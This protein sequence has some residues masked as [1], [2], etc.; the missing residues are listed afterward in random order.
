MPTLYQAF[1]SY[2]NLPKSEKNN[3]LKD[4]HTNS[5]D[6]AN[7]LAALISASQD[8]D[9]IGDVLDQ[10]IKDICENQYVSLTKNHKV[11]VY[12]VDHLLGRGGMSSVYLAHRNDGKF[13]Q[14]V[15]LKFLSSLLTYNKSGQI[16]NFEAQALSKLNHPN[17]AKIHGLEASIEQQ[18]CLVIEYIEGDTLEQYLLKN[19]IN[20]QQ[21]L[22]LFKKI[23]HAIQ[24]AHSQKIIHGDIKPTNIIITPD[25]QPKIIDFGVS[26]QDDQKNKKLIHDYLCALSLGYASPEQINGDSASTLSDVY[27]LGA[28]LS[29]IFIGKTPYQLAQNDQQ[30]LNKTV[31]LPVTLKK[32][33]DK[34]SHISAEKR[35]LTADAIKQDI[36]LYQ[37][38]RPLLSVRYS[39][40]RSFALFYKRNT[41][42]T[43]L[44]SVFLL[45]LVLGFTNFAY[46]N[47]QLKSEQRANT[48]I[49]RSMSKLLNQIDPT[50]GNISQEKPVKA[51]ESL[52][53]SMNWQELNG[54]S[55]IRYATYL[56]SAYTSVDEV[57]KAITLLEGLSGV[58]PKSLLDSPNATYL[59]K[60]KLADL[61]FLLKQHD[62]STENFIKSLSQ[63]SLLTLD[64]EEILLALE[65]RS[66]NIVL[67]STEVL[68]KEFIQWATIKSNKKKLTVRAQVA[69]NSFKVAYYL[70]FIRQKDYQKILSLSKENLALIRKNRETLPAFYY[71]QALIDYYDIIV[72]L[73]GFNHPE[74]NVIPEELRSLLGTTIKR[75]HP[76]YVEAV[77]HLF[78]IFVKTNFKAAIDLYANNRVLLLN[79][80][81]HN[82]RLT[83]YLSR[84]LLKNGEFSEALLQNYQGIANTNSTYANNEN[85]Q[86]L[87]SSSRYYLAN[88]LAYTLGIAP[89]SKHYE[90]LLQIITDETSMPYI[91]IRIRYCDAL[92]SYKDYEKAASICPQVANTVNKYLTEDNSFTLN[93][94]AML[95]TLA[96]YR[97]NNTPEQ[98]ISLVSLIE[99]LITISQ[100][101]KS[102]GQAYQ[103]LFNHFLQQQD[104]KRAYAYLEKI[105]A[106][107]I[108]DKNNVYTLD[109]AKQDV[110]YA[111]YYL[112]TAQLNLGQPYFVNATNYL[113][114]FIPTSNYRY[115]TLLSLSSHYGSLPFS[116]PKSDARQLALETLIS[117]YE[118]KLNI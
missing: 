111:R 81:K 101:K 75:N 61:Y 23:V 115:Q 89:A 63:H 13:E 43:I 45:S 55:A 66:D 58:L 27:A 56:G 26:K 79:A 59:I 4:I 1:I 52:E 95:L 117:D 80:A 68:L 94:N 105:N 51:I 6:I 11:G 30:N 12:T 49:M 78:R 36:D 32:I 73:Y 60:M 71:V 31:K 92:L 97:E 37:Q 33:I 87:I 7:E 53:K 65:S 85:Y 57:G 19:D 54:M 50:I 44:T 47:Y 16:L 18:P 76:G 82:G 40:S 5:P 107:G 83:T 15:A 106:L 42:T 25:H 96:T 108:E 103:H 118:T 21:R 29:F 2:E 46:Q 100:D 104:F 17:I 39:W 20:Q 93:A 69:F 22:N 64:I 84:F 110:L 14:Q 3:Y 77:A 48:L 91:A 99:K 8:V 62:K 10:S 38:N 102:T 90:K 35:Y 98:L 113:C 9:I 86:Y 24:H 72:L 74:L 109:S 28:L 88:T 67:K 34:S 70:G 114:E 112:A 116:C 41:F